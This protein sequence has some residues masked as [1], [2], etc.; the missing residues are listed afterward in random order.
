MV[1]VNTQILSGKLTPKFR[2]KVPG[3]GRGKDAA[4]SQ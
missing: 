1:M 2:G 4:T 3:K